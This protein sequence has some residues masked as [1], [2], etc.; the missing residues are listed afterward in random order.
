M[1]T[2]E[3]EQVV[4]NNAGITFTNLK[5]KLDGANG[6]IQYHLRR[7]DIEK[8]GR[9]YVKKGCCQKCE[10]KQK[11]TGTCMR[12]YLRNDKKKTILQ[13]LDEDEKKLDIAEELSISP[14]TLS[15]HINQ[16][17]EANLLI[18]KKVNPDIE[19]LL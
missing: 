14:A 12:T 15:Y 3:L 2:E 18:E 1:K 5:E 4:E 16:L 6:Q 17:E 11:C 19:P 10:L 7:A 9:G 8:K 13:M